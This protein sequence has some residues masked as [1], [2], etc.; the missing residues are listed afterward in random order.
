MPGVCRQGTPQEHHDRDQSNACLIRKQQRLQANH[1][2]PGGRVEQS[3]P[4]SPQWEPIL[5]TPWSQISSLQDQGTMKV[6]VL[7]TQS[8][9]ILRPHGLQHA[10]LLC[11]WE[12]PGKNTR[13]ACHA[14]L[15][16]I[17]PSQGSNPGLPRCSQIFYTLSHRG[18]PVCCMRQY[19]SII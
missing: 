4:H 1:Q 7:V 6:K 9:P 12:S 13:V 17:F 5:L 11:P 18:S 2:K 16:G 19:I 3:L 14:L 15:Q 8:C 10:R